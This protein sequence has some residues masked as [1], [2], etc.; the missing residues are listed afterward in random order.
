MNKERKFRIIFDNLRTKWL[1]Y[2]GEDGKYLHRYG[3]AECEQMLNDM[4]LLAKGVSPI[5]GEWDDNIYGSYSPIFDEEIS[6]EGDFSLFPNWQ[7]NM[8]WWEV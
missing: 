5:K 8:M 2:N 4:M 1:Y 7:E 3:C 6:K